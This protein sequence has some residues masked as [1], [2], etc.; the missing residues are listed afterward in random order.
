MGAMALHCLHLVPLLP[1]RLFFAQ[2][3]TLTSSKDNT[4][5]SYSPNILDLNIH[6]HNY[7]SHLVGE[8]QS[9]NC[10]IICEFKVQSS[11]IFNMIICER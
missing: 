2:I 8:P 6:T 7:S 11:R 5:I 1:V 9:I 3:D 10:C 4:H